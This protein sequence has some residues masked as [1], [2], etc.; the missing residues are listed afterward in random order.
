[1]RHGRLVWFVPTVR[2][3]QGG[4]GVGGEDTGMVEEG[5]R[6]LGFGV[7]N[8]SVNANGNKGIEM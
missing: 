6:G 3:G 4:G 1:M 5:S 7:P 2:R 8:T